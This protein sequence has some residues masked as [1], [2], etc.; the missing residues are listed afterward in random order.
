MNLHM[1]L[2][3]TLEKITIRL[4]QAEAEALRAAA[5]AARL[6]PAVLARQLLAQALAAGAVPPPPPPA[7]VNLTP[8][9]KA[10]ISVLAGL[11]SNLT[12]LNSHAQEL[13]EPLSK[14]ALPGGVLEAL[15]NQI[16]GL[17]LSI[18]SG[19]TIP[20]QSNERLES[21]AREINS[22]ARRLNMDRNS[23]E[24]SAWH[25]SLTSLKSALAEFK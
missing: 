12:Q 8:P 25:S 7:L 18:K 20:S 5:F 17:G 15:G 22:L 14:L 6:A 24:V 21:A 2:H 1:N 16:Q 9:A 13:G 23:V 11:Q 4:P 10:L 19:M 3:M